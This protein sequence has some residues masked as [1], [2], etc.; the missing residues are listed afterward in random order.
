MGSILDKIKSKFDSEKTFKFS[1][2]DPFSENSSWISTGSPKL[3]YDLR[4]FGFP[5]GIIEIRGES[6][7]GKTTMSLEAIKQAQHQYGNRAVI[8]IL[9]SERRDNKPYATDIGIDLDKV[10]IIRV[11]TIEDTF[12]KVHQIID[13]T[14]E[15]WEAEIQKE[16]KE[17]KD[18]I[19]AIREEKGKPKYF[20]V[21]DSLGQT[22]AAQEKKAMKK[23]ADE[24]SDKHPAMGAAARALGLGLRSVVG[25]V[26]DYDLTFMIINR[27][28]SKTEGVP[29]KV[30][31][32]GT[33]ITLYPCMRLELA[34]KQ[35][36]KSGE[37]EIGQ[38][39]VVKVI[40]SDFQPPRQK[41]DVDIFYGMGFALSTDEIKEGIEAGI[42]EKYH[43]G[44]S[45]MKGK[46]KW[47]SKGQL[48]ELYQEHNKFLAILHKR[49]KRH[50]HEKFLK[51]RESR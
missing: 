4:T 19:Q 35:A 23:R 14:E 44:A 22:I 40:K 49:L 24:N 11:T 39:S 31:Y 28:Y 41:F 17:T 21:W 7:S 12:N 46:L 6:Q 1:E 45:F 2:V 9:S 16:A 8:A 36:I 5:N 37:D 25:L 27:P 33:A 34:R 47:R 43:H 30:S 50:Y 51:E 38:V 10:L 15:I 29:G 32:G 26:D 42:M 3:D 18:N 48:L 20:F 13:E